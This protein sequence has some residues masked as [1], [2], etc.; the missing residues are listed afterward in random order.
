MKYQTAIEILISKRHAL[1]R[2]PLSRADNDELSTSKLSSV[3]TAINFLRDPEGFPKR[4][5]PL[6]C[7]SEAMRTLNRAYA[8]LSIHRND[9]MKDRAAN[10]DAEDPFS[11]RGYMILTCEIYN[12]NQQL[13][14]IEHA[15]TALEVFS[16]KLLQ[17]KGEASSLDKKGA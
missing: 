5:N 2:V 12:C 1:R 8:K 3:V 4:V 11:S 13:L 15:V 9:V 6:V 10:Y 14:D 16:D 7:V 17:I